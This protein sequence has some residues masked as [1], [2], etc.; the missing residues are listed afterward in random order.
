MSGED[1]SLE[2]AV[3]EAEQPC[4]DTSVEAARVGAQ[5]HK[6]LARGRSEVRGT[7]HLAQTGA[8]GLAFFAR[9]ANPVRAT[10]SRR[11]SSAFSFRYCREAAW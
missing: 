4:L 2:D 11:F 7:E 3:C 9:A 1:R 6:L 5:C 8:W 10:R